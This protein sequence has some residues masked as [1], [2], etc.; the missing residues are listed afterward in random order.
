MVWRPFGA[1][2]DVPSRMK[3]VLP[4]SSTFDCLPN[5]VKT[6]NVL[7]EIKFPLILQFVTFHSHSIYNDWQ[8]EGDR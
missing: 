4:Q 3:S 5:F 6:S 8:Q 7:P 2:F 1:G